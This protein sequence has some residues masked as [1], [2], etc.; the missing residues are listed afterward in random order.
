MRKK[1]WTKV[2]FD[3]QTTFNKVIL[4]ILNV[5]LLNCGKNT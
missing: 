3:F 4:Y 5:Y 1:Y 2:S